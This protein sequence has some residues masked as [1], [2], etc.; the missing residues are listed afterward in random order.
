MS[1]RRNAIKTMALLMGG[2]LSAPTLLAMDRWAAAEGNPPRGNLALEATDLA[3]IASVAELIIPETD[4]P[5]ATAAGV[6]EFIVMMLQDCYHQPEQESFK[7]GL[8]RLRAENF[9]A[10]KEPQQISLLQRIEQET[11]QEMKKRNVK[12]TKMGDNEDREQ[13]DKKAVGLPFWRLIKELTLLG[14]FTSE[15]GLTTAFDYVPIPGRFELTTLKP[16]QK[17]FAY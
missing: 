14:Y 2:A 9:L 11:M 3:L 12:Q 7:Q 4:T 16:G 5:G 6:P 15:Q 13:I 10:M 1:N 8:D 17:A